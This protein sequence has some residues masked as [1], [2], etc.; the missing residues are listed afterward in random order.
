[1]SIRDY[2]RTDWQPA[3]WVQHTAVTVLAGV[4]IEIVGHGTEPGLGYVLGCACMTL[5]FVLIREYGQKQ[6]Y[7]EAGTYDDASSGISPRDDYVGD[8]LGPVAVTVSAMLMA[9]F[10][11][12]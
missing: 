10:L 3:T 12:G 7:K 9:A 1:M 6:A 2:L 4:G 11:A 8:I 5:Y